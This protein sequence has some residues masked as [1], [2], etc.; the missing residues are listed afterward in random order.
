[1]S[2]CFQ[3]PRYRYHRMHAVLIPRCFHCGITRYRYI[4]DIF[5]LVDICGITQS[6]SMPK[7]IW[8]VATIPQPVRFALAYCI[9]KGWLRDIFQ[10]V[11]FFRKI[12]KSKFFSISSLY[13][14]K[15]FWDRQVF[16]VLFS[17]DSR[18]SIFQNCCWSVSVPLTYESVSRFSCRRP[19]GYICVVLSVI[20]FKVWSKI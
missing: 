6:Y 14:P 16:G 19:D 1:M 11:S 9:S 5:I 17:V 20:K 10:N 4:S 12:S 7:Q 13:V 2:P 8:Q 15:I 3:I 18:S